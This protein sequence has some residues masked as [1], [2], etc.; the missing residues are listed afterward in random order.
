[1]RKAVLCNGWAPWALVYVDG[2][3]Y[4]FVTRYEGRIYHQITIP[5][6][7]HLNVKDTALIIEK[8][9]FDGVAIRREFT[10]RWHVIQ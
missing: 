1:M 3:W 8:R 6:V 2:E 5:D 9:A 10:V 7:D 4:D